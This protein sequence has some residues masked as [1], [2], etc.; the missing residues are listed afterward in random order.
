MVI[1]PV[2]IRDAVNSLQSNVSSGTI[3]KYSGLVVFVSALSGIFLY[4][5]RQ[6]II[7]VSRHIENDL[8]NDFMKHLT[9]LSVRYFQN[10]PT[11]DI[12]AHSTNDIGAVR[13]FVGP[14]LMY[15]TETIFT[16]LIILTLMIQ[17]HPMLTVYALL[18]LPL[19]SYAVHRVGA[20][21]HRRFEE[22]QEHYS[23][24]TA[25]AQENLAGIR[26]VKSY[27]R[28]ENETEKFESLSKEY[29]VRNIRMAKI[30][31]LFMP[32]LQILV[33]LSVI[34]VV[35]YGG[36]QVVRDELSMG[37]LTQFLIYISMLIWPMIA[38]GWVISIIQRAAASMKRIQRILDQ[39]PEIRDTERTDYSIS[40]ITG[41]IEFEK[42]S[43]QYTRTSDVVLDTI[44]L[45]IPQGM[46]IA[47]MGFTGSGKS[48]FTHLIPRL[49]DVTGGMLRID[50]HDIRSIPVDVLRKNISYVTQET[51]L[52][53]DSLK[54]NI[55]YGIDE[56]DMDRVEWAA[57]VARLDK[58]IID[59]P[60]QYETMLGERGITLSGGQKQRVSLARAILRDPAILIL[61]DALSAV[62]THT[63]EEILEQLKDVMRN[64]TTIIISHRISTVKNADHIIVLN[65]GKIWESGQHE[66]LVEKGG[67]Y[68]ELHCKQLLT[69]ELEDIE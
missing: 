5:Q 40:N 30:Q 11:G 32:L 64:R 6:T 17:I 27:F 3:L 41:S 2:L 19:V 69:Q 67:I 16:F 45:K 37:E 23:M 31:A 7:V 29:L 24:L 66:T 53:S 21:I 68:A 25:S 56:F 63:E 1:V 50:D 33:G 20:I 9:L 4:L 62:D 57:H 43:F 18:P 35:W 22:I 28:E 46:T 12:M 60:H 26:V 8:R 34:I 42:V 14:A 61:D 58:D 13:M 48:T 36:L 10:T 39:E 44:S 54:A 59:F 51:F 49:Y 52:F 65:E 47:V 55:A 15:S 38:I